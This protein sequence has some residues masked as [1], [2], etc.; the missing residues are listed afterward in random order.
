MNLTL[1]EFGP[2]RAARCLWVLREIGVPFERVEVD[3]SVGA[4]R[5]PEFLAINPMGRVPALV[6][7]GTVLT[8]SM[9]ICTWLADRYPEARLIPAAGSLDR[10]VHDRWMFFCA[11]ELDAPLWRIR[12][13]TVLLPEE[14]RVA[15]DVP[16]ASHDFDEAATV[17]ES[18]LGDR[19]V[20]V[21]GRFSV[22]DVVMTHTL[23][24]SSWGHGLD[25]HPGLSRYVERHLRR[26][27]CPAVLRR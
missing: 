13:N 24:W 19:E 27:A 16:L 5:K 18:F 15:G 14:R 2:T 25:G 10:A 6:A 11:T 7:D 17:F 12:R 26:P 4:H 23:Q 9:A 21:G 8:E 22:V 3:L 1:Y 20:V